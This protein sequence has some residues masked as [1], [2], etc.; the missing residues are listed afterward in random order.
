MAADTIFTNQTPATTDF[1][2]SNHGWGML[3]AVSDDCSCTGGRAY[4]P[5]AGRPGT[6]FWQLW[7]VG[8][9]TKLAETN[10][11]AAS[12]G[13][14]TNNTWMS[15]D[16][17]LFTSPGDIAL[18]SAE[19]YIVNV[20]FVGDGLFTDPG[21]FPIGSGGLVSSSTGRYNNGS[22]QNAM[23]GTNS[24]TYFFADVDAES[25]GTE[26]PKSVAGTITPAGS[27]SKAVSRTVTGS[28][29]PTGALTKAV[30]RSLAG[31]TTPSGALA[32]QTAR[33]L[34]GAATPAGTL[35]KQAG[36]S[37]AGVAAPAGS[38]AKETSRALA[39]STTPAG[40]IARTV[41]KALDGTIAPVGA[42]VSRAITRTLSGTIS[43]AGTVLKAL[44]RLL[45]GTITPTGSVSSAPA[46]VDV[47]TSW[48]VGKPHGRWHTGTP[49][50]RWHIGPPGGG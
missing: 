20:Y 11:N 35:A 44:S 13:T 18:D 48:Q 24:A 29:T 2:G 27:L 1:D 6:F 36:R 50:G 28:T 17:S 34:A 38:V 9:S 7:R 12:H 41:G 45:G 49:R 40:S 19:E 14:P 31:S 32:K 43:P 23:P 42:I 15:F 8:D 16:S 39:G 33:A 25:A 10:L 37:L 4:V 22:G 30:S 26:Y 47:A 21:T 3:F 5:N 46:A